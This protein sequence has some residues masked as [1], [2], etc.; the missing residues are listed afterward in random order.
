MKWSG[1]E[2]WKPKNQA[3]TIEAVEH[4][5]QSFSVGGSNQVVWQIITRFPT[6]RAYNDNKEILKP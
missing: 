1:A 2:R 4:V 6:T 5:S 3:V